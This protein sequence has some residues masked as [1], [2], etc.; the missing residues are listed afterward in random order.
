MFELI[1][2]VPLILLSALC[3]YAGHLYGVRRG[4]AKEASSQLTQHYFQG[5]N[6]LLNEQP[7]QAIDTFIRS[8]DVTPATLET[9]L[10]LGN[11]MRQRGE[12]ERAIRV[13]QNLLS[14]PNLNAQQLRQA[15]LELGRDFLKAGLFDRAERLFLDLV[16]DESGALRQ[17]SLLHLVDIYR[18]EKEWEKAIRAA[19]MLDKKRFGRSPEG[20][21]VEQA[22]FCCELAAKAMAGGDLLQARGHLKSALKYN[23]NSSRASML[24]GKLEGLS[25]NHALALKRYLAVPEQQPDYLTEILAP[26][27]DCY[28]LV[29]DKPGLLRQLSGWLDRYPSAS[30]LN[31]VAEELAGQQG[32]EAAISFLGDY[33]ERHP[34]LKGLNALLGFYWQSEETVS[35]HLEL[36]KNTLSTLINRNPAYRC[37]QCGFKGSHLHW[38]CPQ[39]QQWETVRPLRGI[40]GE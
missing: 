27:R 6:F 38:L 24:W 19:S 14:R 15:R 7:D 30:L 17:A 1:Y 10:A 9:H 33:L 5:I 11:L 4:R 28:Q 18:H 22:N 40:D 12:M 13:H 26:V 25:N 34:S 3:W 36:V 16:D 29:G 32:D 39:C 2:V 8:V 35:R 31:M 21:A 20:L 37:I 23:R